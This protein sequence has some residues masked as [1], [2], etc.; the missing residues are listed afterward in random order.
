MLWIWGLTVPS[1]LHMTLDPLFNGCNIFLGV[2]KVLTDLV[3]LTA[4]HH[5]GLGRLARLRL[6]RPAAVLDARREMV[7]TAIG[8]G[9]LKVQVLSSGRGVVGEVSMILSVGLSS[10]GEI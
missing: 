8:F 4:R 3:D 2:F 10:R 5:A 6:D 1:S 7:G 9:V